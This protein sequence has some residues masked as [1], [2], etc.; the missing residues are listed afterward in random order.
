MYCN[1][2]AVRNEYLFSAIEQTQLGDFLQ[3]HQLSLYHGVPVS[4]LSPMDGSAAPPAQDGWI[5]FLVCQGDAALLAAYMP[6]AKWDRG[7]SPDGFPGLLTL[8]LPDGS[9][10]SMCSAIECALESLLSRGDKPHWRF[11]GR[12]VPPERV[13]E[14][15]R[16]RLVELSYCDRLLKWSPTEYGID[17]GLV[18]S[19]EFS[20]GQDIQIGI[21]CSERTRVNLEKIL[22]WEPAGAGANTAEAIPLSERIARLDQGLCGSGVEAVR[23]FANTPLD[24]Y[25]RDFPE[26]LARMRKALPALGASATYQDAAVLVYWLMQDRE[27]WPEELRESFLMLY[28]GTGTRLMRDLALPLLARVQSRCN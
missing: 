1:N 3:E 27:L 25:M 15:A 24:D 23:R 5:T 8:E 19:C 21:W 14:L 26:E 11:L 17:C 9:P 28:P 13:P 18:Q 6:R 4:D 7:D 20:D 12:P 10:I 16:A 2:I 22:A